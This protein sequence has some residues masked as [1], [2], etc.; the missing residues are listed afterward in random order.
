[1]DMKILISNAYCYL[2]KGDAG[3]IRAMVQEFRKKHP[4]A[5][6]KVVSLFKD[7]DQ[8]KYG[9]CEVIDCIIK[10]Y[11]GKSR[12]MKTIRNTALYFL[13]WLLNLLGIPFN[14]TVR[15]FKEADI[16][17]SCGGGYLKARNLAQFL[18]DFMYHYIQFLT[19]IQ[20]KK[21]FVVYAQTVGEFGSHPY[22]TSRI[23]KVLNKAA[24]VLPREPISYNYLKGF[25]PDNRNF[26]ETSDIAFLLEKKEI[27]SK[28]LKGLLAV[29]KTK[30]GITMRSWHFPGTPNRAWQLENYKNAMSKLIE[31]LVTRQNAEVF[32]MPQCIGP[33]EDNDLL[34]SRE[35]YAPFQENRSVHLV[36]NNLTPEELKYVYSQMDLFVGTRMHSNIFALSEKVPCVAISYDLKTDGIMKAVGLKDYVLDIKDLNEGG[37]RAKIDQALARRDLMKQT[38]ETSIPQICSKARMNNT[39]LYQVMD[40]KG[41][42]TAENRKI[43]ELLDA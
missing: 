39:L 19:A 6:I 14:R 25:V 1:M 23:K 32:L 30:V 29:K 18:G 17:V 15:E 13:V 22:V 9:N 12:L 34:I 40:N 38:L 7:L 33:G 36:D 5:E 8:G 10:P 16:V 43:G 21:P 41:K 2:N 4:R 3:I 27:D 28:S 37:L 20:Y 24:L 42:Q 31:H 35:V 26:F 11:T